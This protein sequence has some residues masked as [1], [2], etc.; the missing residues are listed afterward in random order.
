MLLSV[1]VC[2]PSHSPNHVSPKPVNMCAI[3]SVNIAISRTI[4]NAIPP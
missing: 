3:F 2:E 1:L 4:T